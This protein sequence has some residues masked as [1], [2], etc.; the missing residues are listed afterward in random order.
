MKLQPFA[1]RETELEASQ[2]PFS[3][4]VLAHLK[5]RQTRDDPEARRLCKIQLVRGL[6]ES[7]L[8]AK[9]VRELFNVID[10]MMRLPGK[11]SKLFW[12]DVATM[13]KEKQMPFISTPER[14]GRCDGMRLG[15]KTALK[16]K[17]GD[18]GLTLMPAVE[19][20]YEEKQ[21]QAVLDSLETATSLEEVRRIL[22]QSSD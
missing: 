15:I 17:F 19:E 1:Q 7:G 2:N 10:W 6:Y 13:Q 11:L 8:G 21:L 22:A 5:A 4:V 12:K 16:M 9:D 14:V 3:K 18:E 20:T